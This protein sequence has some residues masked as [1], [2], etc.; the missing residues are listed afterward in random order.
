MHDTVSRNIK[1]EYKKY[2]FIVIYE[3]MKRAPN[4]KKNTVELQK[5]KR[6]AGLPW[7]DVV[8]MFHRPK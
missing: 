1:K 7:P 6:T 8:F 3:G 2:K 5:G 4:L